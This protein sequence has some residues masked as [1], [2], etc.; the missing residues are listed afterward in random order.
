MSRG[1]PRQGSE[2]VDGIEC[3]E[4]AKARTRVI[5]AA[6]LG[7]C[8]VREAC[9]RLGISAAGFYKLRAKALEGLA[10]GLEPRPAGR[11]PHVI[12]EE[13]VHNQVLEQEIQDLQRDLHAAHIRE[14]IAL[15][16]P[17]LVKGE[18]DQDK[19]KGAVKNRKKRRRR[20]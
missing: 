5:L 19:K 18:P 1:R 20:P 11:R 9:T 10:R 8:S 7:E 13:E 4:I 16:M 15:M 14:E 12:T 3:S 17:H 6:L 2:L